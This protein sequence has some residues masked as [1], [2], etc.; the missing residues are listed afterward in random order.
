MLARSL[1]QR[2][3]LRANR[4]VL[5]QTLELP[6]PKVSNSLLSTRC[7][8]SKTSYLMEK[9]TVN[10]PS[11]GDSIT[12]G[13]IVSWTVN[14]GQSVKEGDVLALVETDKVTVDIKAQMDGIIT[15]QFGKQ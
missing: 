11:M 3:G 13:T 2:L 8:T 1:G 7:F 15:A 4:R 9:I 6:S 14:V 10:V 5:F 12:E